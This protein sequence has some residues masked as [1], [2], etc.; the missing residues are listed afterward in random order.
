MSGPLRAAGF[1]TLD[2]V[3]L[4]IASSDP[5]PHRPGPHRHVRPEMV[6]V[7]LAI[8]GMI[9]LVAV[10]IVVVKAWRRRRQTPTQT[11]KRR[12]SRRRR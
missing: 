3:A 2:S 10:I 8:V 7:K 12:S 11:G 4:L 9:L 5:P 6:P 1:E